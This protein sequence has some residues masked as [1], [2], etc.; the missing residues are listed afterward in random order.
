V[1]RVLEPGKAAEP[2]SVQPGVVQQ[3][4]QRSLM[5]A[6]GLD[7]SKSVD[8]AAAVLWDDGSNRLLVHLD[9]TTVR[10]GTGVVDVSLVVEC[11]QTQ[12]AA[13]VC[14]FVTTS[15]D[16]PGG[17]VWATQ[18]RPRGP[19]QVVQVWGDSL[20]ALCWRALVDVA[21]RAA[22]DVGVDPFGRSTIAATVVAGPDGLMITPMAPHRF[23]DLGR[24]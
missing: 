15:P 20:V 19:Q 24:Q 17:F 8:P 13:V 14:T 5:T 2:I 23:M 18:D 11:D 6:A 10:F 9:Q 16:R 22:A 12:R 1:R 3:L 4:L 21:V 7:P